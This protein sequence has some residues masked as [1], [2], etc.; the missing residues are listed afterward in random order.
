MK[1]MF[2]LTGILSMMLAACEKETGTNQL[3]ATAVITNET[4]TKTTY[5]DPGSEG[6]LKVGWSDNDS[7]K[8]YY[9]S[10]EYVTFTR[11]SGNT[12]TAADVSGGIISSSQFQG[13][14]EFTGVYGENVTYMADGR[15]SADFSGQDGTL[16]NLAKYDF[17]TCQSTSEN[18]VLSFAFKHKCAILKANLVNTSG[19]TGKRVEIRI[20]NA[21][22]ADD[23]VINQ[24]PSTSSGV[25]VSSGDVSVILFL[26][27]AL[28]KGETRTIY[29]MV[30]AMAFKSSE[31]SIPVI[32][33]T[34]YRKYFSFSDDAG[35][36][37]AFEAGKMYE[38]TINDIGG[39]TSE[40]N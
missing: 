38:T 36:L 26:S 31:G 4:E 35:K 39:V 22:I 14:H 15:L 21:E 27:T 2:V 37:S 12:F 33:G 17:M 16:E 13:V 30:P 20:A 5:S 3:S 40:Q 7:F 28:S 6:A 29:I 24:N 19:T 34:G 18:G 10:S 23:F 32:G 8:A 9:S 1:K 25:N 11:S